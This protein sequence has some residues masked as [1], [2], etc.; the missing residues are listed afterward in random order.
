MDAGRGMKAISGQR[1]AFEDCQD[2]AEGGTTGT[3]RRRCQNIIATIAAAKRL[4]LD[5]AIMRGIVEAEDTA[6]RLAGLD[7]RSGN[8]PLIESAWPVRGDFLQR[9]CQGCLRQ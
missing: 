2:L 3:R 5:H 1:V 6:V 9:G 7:N 8:R 4:A